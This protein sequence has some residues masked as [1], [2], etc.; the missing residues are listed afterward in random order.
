MPLK[1]KS[2]DYFLIP[3]AEVPVTNLHRDEILAAEQLPIA[4]TA[5]SANFRS[6]ASA[7][8]KAVNAGPGSRP[9]SS[10]S[11]CRAWRSVRNASACWP[12]RYCA[13]ASTSQRRSRSG[14]SATR[15]RPRPAHRRGAR[16]AEPRPSG[17]PRHRAAAPPGGWPRSGPAP[18][19][20]RR[21]SPVLA[22]TPTPRRSGQRRDSVPPSRPARGRVRRDARS[23]ASRSRRPGPPGD[24]R[25]PPSRSPHF[26]ASAAGAPPTPGSAWATSP[27]GCHATAHRRG[28]RHRP[29]RHGGRPGRPAPHGHGARAHRHLR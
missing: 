24:T 1:L 16:H 13:N 11:R 18:N 20:P 7:S 25:P 21:R 29:P 2:E 23:A 17:R 22:T 6:E 26:P 12:D 28:R 19:R 3:T 4:Y 14:C 9:S 27:A 10:A 15:A 5:Y 8:S